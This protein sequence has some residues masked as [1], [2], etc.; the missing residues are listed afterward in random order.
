M[1]SILGKRAPAEWT[2]HAERVAHGFAKSPFDNVGVRYGLNALNSRAITPAQFLDLNAKVGGTD[3]DDNF[4]ASRDVA[5]PGSLKTLYSSGQVNDGRG[6]AG[7]AIVSLQDWSETH[8]IHTSFHSWEMRTRLDRDNGNHR[9]QVIWTYPASS[10]LAGVAPDQFV[11][12]RSFLL[13]DRWLSAVEADHRSASLRVKVARDKPA[14]A[15]DA[16]FTSAD[17]EIVSSATCRRMFPRYADARIA[18]GGPLADDL[19][20]CRLKPLERSSYA[21]SFTDAQWAEM[22]RI[23]PT[24]V[25]DWKLPGIGQQPSHPWTGFTGGPGGRPLGAA[26]QSTAIPARG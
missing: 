8:E 15:V 20:Q 2:S 7:V 24:G 25:C 26:P 23:F 12:L 1:V 13:M 14:A 11:T 3:I 5:D 10:A 4:I 16:C 9:N 21:I 22:Q 19:V 17:Q 18:A 6:L